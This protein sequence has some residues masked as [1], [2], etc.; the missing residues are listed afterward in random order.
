MLTI[1][2][3]KHNTL[4]LFILKEFWSVN[5]IIMNWWFAKLQ[6]IN[7]AYIY[8][9]SFVLERII[10]HFLVYQ[11]YC[12]LVSSVP[13]MILVLYLA[14][15]VLSSKTGCNEFFL[16]PQVFLGFFTS[17]SDFCPFPN[18]WNGTYFYY[19][20]Y[21][22]N[23]FPQFR[24]LSYLCQQRYNQDPIVSVIGVKLWKLIKK[25]SLPNAKLI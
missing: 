6:N 23:Y 8:S 2:K 1:N 18:S 16:I 19:W 14:I 20:P 12:F 17:I 21:S 25:L 5:K 15:S 7:Y 10:L 11:Y 24:F 22:F 4:I 13:G 3:T 9:C